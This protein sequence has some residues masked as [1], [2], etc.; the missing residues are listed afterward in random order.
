M[1]AYGYGEAIVRLTP[2]SPQAIDRMEEVFGW[3][4]HLE[5]KPHLTVAMWLTCGIGMGPKRAGDIIGVHRDT[6]RTRRDEA[7]DIMVHALSYAKAKAA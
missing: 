7:L 4:V 3:F 5:G 2:A 1:Q 6:V